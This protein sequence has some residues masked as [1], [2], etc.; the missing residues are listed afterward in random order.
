MIL[1]DDPVHAQELESMVLVGPF[2]IF[3]FCWFCDSLYCFSA[4]FLPVKFLIV[5]RNDH[6]ALVYRNTFC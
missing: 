4:L 3:M 6:S 2:P 1:G 5:S